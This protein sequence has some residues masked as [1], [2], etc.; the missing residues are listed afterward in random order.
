VQRL[1][2]QE[3][4]VHVPRR[5][6]AG[7]TA[8]LVVGFLPGSDPRLRDA[9]V[10]VSAHLD[11]LGTGQPATNGDSIYNGADDNA[12]GVAVMLAVARELRAA[13]KA[14][15]RSVLFVA[16][17]GEEHGFWGSDYF[18]G[19]ADTPV[20]R[21]VANINVDGV[22]RPAWVDS[23]AVLGGAWS[24]LGDAARLAAREANVGIAPSFGPH[25]RYAQSDH[26]SF[27]RR[28]IPSVHVYSG[29]LHSYYHSPDDQLDVIDFP[30]LTRLTRYVSA[31]VAHVGN[32]SVRPAWTDSYRTTGKTPW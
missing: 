31:L 10:V 25:A 3:V 15:R 32:E 24:T 18:V 4:E 22:G 13:G 19:S 7:M 11:H 26:Y 29:K 30:W 9:L 1:V 8:P 21:M 20:E 17:S 28:G 16:T 6:L 2:G 27:A 5:Q 23:V 12:S 14:P